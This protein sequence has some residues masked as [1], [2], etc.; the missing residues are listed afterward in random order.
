MI[1]RQERVYGRGPQF[2]ILISDDGGRVI[3]VQHT[4]RYGKA[5][6]RAVSPMS[7]L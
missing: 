3:P 2:L 5:L 1:G 4:D 7:R 6:A